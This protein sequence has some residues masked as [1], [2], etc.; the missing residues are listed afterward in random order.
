[1]Q[2]AD[3]PSERARKNGLLAMILFAVTLLI[4]GLMV[5]VVFGVR[6]GLLPRF[7][8]HALRVLLD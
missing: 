4:L 2:A 3:V 7:V 1:M 8:E 6:S 5:S